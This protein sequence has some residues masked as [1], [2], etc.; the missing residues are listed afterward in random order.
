MDQPA[1]DATMQDI[2]ASGC[3]G[4]EEYANWLKE[5]EGVPREERDSEHYPQE[6][7]M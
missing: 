4:L 1:I 7:G 2:I 3:K 5:K 6:I